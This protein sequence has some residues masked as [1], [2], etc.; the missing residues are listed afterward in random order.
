M[1]KI[2]S[3]A[4]IITLTVSLFTACGVSGE[5]DGSSQE[6]ST[7][8]VRQENIVIPA[9]METEAQLREGLAALRDKPDVQAQRLAFY[10]ELLARDLC[11]EEDYQEMSRLYADMGD[12]AAQRRMLWWAFR[13]YP[14][15]EYARQL[16]ELVVQR[17]ADE[18]QAAGIAMAVKQ[19]LSERDAVALRAAIA[20]DSW[21]ET[22][23][24]APE[25][26][27]TR[28]RYTDGELTAQIVSDAYAT[29]VLL[30]AADGTCLYGRVNDAGSLIASAVYTDGAYNGDAEVCW[31]DAENT[32]YKKYQA[33]LRNDVCVDSI[34]VEY[35][36]I[37]YQGTLGED[38]AT[39]ERQQEKVTEAGGVVYAYQEGG[40]RYLYQNETTTD[41]FR[42]DYLTIGLPHMDIWE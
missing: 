25:I 37:P 29:E 27:A 33:V 41:T 14:S 12:T 32:V 39:T 2:S 28:T 30:L 22:F 23:Q 11:R 9:Q 38:G 18:E 3:V 20:G 5:S 7:D 13:L 24:E 42:M 15:E 1:R 17:T 16:Q 26:Y 8:P 31:F 6:A 36:G 10:E 35:E 19:A 40:S 21:Q 34:F 4:L